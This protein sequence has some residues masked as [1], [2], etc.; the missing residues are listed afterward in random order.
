MSVGYLQYITKIYKQTL[1]HLHQ[2]FN[3]EVNTG[4]VNTASYEDKQ[5]PAT[6]VVKFI[7]ITP[8]T[9]ITTPKRPKKNKKNPLNVASTQDLTKRI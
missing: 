7:L 1:L 9:N 6:C 5:L 4:L 8:T 3:A 2:V